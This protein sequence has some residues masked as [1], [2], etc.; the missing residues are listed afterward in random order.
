[1]K[2]RTAEDQTAYILVDRYFPQNICNSKMFPQNLIK[3][4]TNL[5]FSIIYF[6][7]FETS[8]YIVLLS[9][10]CCCYCYFPHQQIWKRRQ[11]QRC[12]SA[13]GWPQK[14]LL[15][16]R[17]E[18]IFSPIWNALQI[19]ASQVGKPNELVPLCVLDFYVAERRQRSGCGSKLFQQMLVD[20]RAD[21]R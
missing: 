21:P 5:M 8:A 20:Q 7:D 13:Q 3:F 2:F 14:A 1:M 19:E 12:R 10:S 17:G 6:P 18:E 15:A 9:L 16:W 4:P 11:G